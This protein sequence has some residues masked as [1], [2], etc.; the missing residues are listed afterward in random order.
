MRRSP[1]NSQA[2][3]WGRA[4]DRVKA[5][6]GELFATPAETPLLEGVRKTIARFKSYASEANPE[7]GG[8]G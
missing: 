7:N 1:D 4:P 3:A 5:H 6:N 8:A 2:W